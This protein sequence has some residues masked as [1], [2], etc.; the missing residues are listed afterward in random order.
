MPFALNAMTLSGLWTLAA[1]LL[2][3][4]K[5]QFC[6]DHYSAFFWH[7]FNELCHDLMH[8]SGSFQRIIVRRTGSLYWQTR[9]EYRSLLPAVHIIACLSVAAETWVNSVV[10]LLFLQ[11][12]P[13]P[14]KLVLASRFQ[15]MDYACFQVSSHNTLILFGTLF[16]GGALNLSGHLAEHWPPSSAK[17]KNTAV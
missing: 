3:Y 15:A 8:C 6:N 11:A 14:R 12:Y 2:H 7:S 16:L 13:F 5:Y 4:V 17:F 9:T 1:I 10:T